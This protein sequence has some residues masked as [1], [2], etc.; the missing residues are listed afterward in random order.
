MLTQIKARQLKFLNLF[1]LS[2]TSKSLLSQP[3][4]GKTDLRVIKN[5]YDINDLEPTNLPLALREH[6]TLMC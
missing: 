2:L 6:P 4:F 1:R 3:L 5:V